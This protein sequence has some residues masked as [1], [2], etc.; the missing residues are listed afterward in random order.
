MQ[1]E[2]SST[3]APFSWIATESD[4][5][6]LQ[7]RGQ[8]YT[9]RIVV[10]SRI[11]AHWG[12]PELTRSLRTGDLREARRRLAL[13][14]A[15]MGAFLQQVDRNLQS[16]TRDEVDALYR[17]YL[18]TKFDE[19]EARLS[20]PL[21]EDQAN[22]TSFYLNDEAHRISAALAFGHVEERLPDAA[23]MPPAA[24]EAEQRRLARRLL[25]ADLKATV[26]ELNALEGR[27]LELPQETLG[28]ACVTKDQ[29]VSSPCSRRWSGCTARSI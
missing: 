6:V 2:K 1:W 9:S 5:K 22:G 11:R 25:E 15:H 26:A 20:Q 24:S 13:W 27:P 4:Q 7:R 10:P 28:V 16:M 17:H 19:I 23:Q 29:A 12:R 8:I 21:D 3:F 14:E 18:T